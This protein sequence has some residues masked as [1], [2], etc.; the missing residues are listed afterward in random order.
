MYKSRDAVYDRSEANDGQRGNDQPFIPS[1]PGN[2]RVG[3][4]EAEHMK[5]CRQLCR[6]V[7]KFDDKLYDVVIKCSPFYVGAGDCE[8]VQVTKPA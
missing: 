8:I 4:G 2:D 6:D 5:A 3:S 1:D 7:R